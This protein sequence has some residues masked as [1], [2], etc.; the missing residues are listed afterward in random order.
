MGGGEGVG[1]SSSSMS[2]EVARGYSMRWEEVKVSG[3][4]CQVCRL[5]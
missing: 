2:S 4:V 5:K 1:N 3:I